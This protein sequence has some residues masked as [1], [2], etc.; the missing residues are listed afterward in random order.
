MNKLGLAKIVCILSVFCTAT[1]MISSAQTFNV[2]TNFDGTNGDGPV[3]M[4]LVLGTDGNFYGTTPL[5]GANSGGTVFRVTTTGKLTTIYSSCE[6]ANCADGVN[7]AT[8]LVLGTDGFF[9]GT[10]QGGGTSVN[11]TGTIFKISPGGVL[12]TLYSFCAQTDCADG[13]LRMTRWFK[14]RTGTSTARPT[15]VVSSLW[16]R[17]SKSALQ[18]RL[19][20]FTTF[21]PWVNVWMARTSMAG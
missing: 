4:D 11:N 6:L 12:K 19:P 18:A 20:S 9:Y 10:T 3:Y 13:N 21:V 5:G 17:S 7:P 8:G 14:A 2:L 15:R 1:A 16:A